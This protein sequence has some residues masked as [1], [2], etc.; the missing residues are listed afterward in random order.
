ML[1]YN[2][3]WKL[4]IDRGMTRSELRKQIG[5][6]CGS[7]AKMGKNEPVSMDIIMRICENLNCDVGDIMEMNAARRN[8]H[9][10]DRNDER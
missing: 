2:K 1:S 6:S 9:E 8:I 5:M 10:N 4:L 7:L 3:L